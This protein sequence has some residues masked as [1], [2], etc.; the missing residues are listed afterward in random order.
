MDYDGS[1][2]SSRPAFTGLVSRLLQRWG[3]ALTQEGLCGNQQKWSG[4]PATSLCIWSVPGTT[5]GRRN[6]NAPHLREFGGT[7]TLQLSLHLILYFFH[8]FFFFSSLR[9]T[10]WWRDFSPIGSLAIYWIKW[11]IKSELSFK[12]KGVHLLGFSAIFISGFLPT[13]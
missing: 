7:Q 10:C 9:L 2:I 8:H 6:K 5:G 4:A 11:M 1:G 3:W 13:C 12:G